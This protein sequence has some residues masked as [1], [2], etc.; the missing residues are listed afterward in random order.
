MNF[1]KYLIYWFCTFELVVLTALI[2]NQNI[3]SYG[4]SQL[5][6]QLNIIINAR[7][8]NEVLADPEFPDT[9]KSKLILIQEIKAFAIDSIGINNS[10]NYNTV[11]DQ[12][13][14]SILWVL[15]ASEPYELKAYEWSFPFLGKVSYKGFFN[16]NKGK[17]EL[18]ALKSLHYDA[19]M[20]QVG[21]WS[22]LGLFNDP[23]LSNM[24]KLDEGRLANLI[25]HE[26][27]H[28]TLY[29]KGDVDFNENL[30]SFIGDQ[31]ALRF[32]AYKYGNHSVEMKKYLESNRDEKVYDKYIIENAKRLDSLYDTIKN[33]KREIK[34]ELK[35]K[36]LQDII[37]GA[38]KLDLYEKEKYARLT[39][40]IKTHKNAFFMS[41]I[42]YSA[43]QHDFENEL[44]LTFNN[45]LKEYLHY[46][47]TIYPSI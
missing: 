46:L 5:K 8:I 9:L 14:K 12:K 19:E 26:L 27:T 24:L 29:V 23:I 10:N 36:M 45:D 43:K 2:Y 3:I 34:E 37:S 20:S 28:G 15:S 40:K 33:E 42:R 47:K 44:H 25:I 4:L 30:A 21:A 18:S 22:T 41:F 35:N 11:F 32:L 39:K 16:L 17:I 13:G 1:K 38:S 7:P 6:G 31:G